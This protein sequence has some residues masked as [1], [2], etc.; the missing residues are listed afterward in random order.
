MIPLIGFK[1]YWFLAV[2]FFIKVIHSA[3]ECSSCPEKLHSVFWVV[4]FMFQVLS[5]FSLPIKIASGLY[6]H[7]GYILRRKDYISQAKNPGMF[8]GVMLF[9]AGALFFFIPYAYDKANAFTSIGA[10]MCSCLGL[11]IVFYARKINYSR[12][13]AE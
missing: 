12:H 10:A 8:L 2:L 6:F 13:V 9:T 3:F 7:I 1:E 5:G 4:I 11:F